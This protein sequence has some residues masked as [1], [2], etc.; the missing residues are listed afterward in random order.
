M[1]NV[2]LIFALIFF[3][4]F[5]VVWWYVHTHEF[6]WIPEA[7]LR[8]AVPKLS[9]L[10]QVDCDCSAETV[11]PQGRIASQPRCKIWKLESKK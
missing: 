6:S 2:A 9:A 1:Q 8:A 3:T 4:V 10:V 11:C 5:P 7:K